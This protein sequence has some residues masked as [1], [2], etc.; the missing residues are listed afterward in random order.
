MR[1]RLALCVTLTLVPSAAWPQG[2]NPLGPEFRVNTFT[3]DYQT[4]P[5]IAADALG[6]FVVVWQSRQQDGSGYGI[7]GQRYSSSGVPLGLEF[8]V[9]SYTTGNQGWSSVAADAAGNFVVVWEGYQGP[10]RS[11]FGQRYAASGLPLGPEFRVNTYLG[12]DQTS[13]SVAADP[14]G[15]FVVVWTSRD[16]DGSSDGV[17]GQRFAASGAPLGPE[18]RVN[19]FTS[20]SQR[21]PAVAVGPAGTFVVAWES[22]GQ[23]GNLYLTGV[24]AQRFASSG[25]PLGPEFR[26]NT[27]TTSLQQGADVAIDGAGNFLVVWYGFGQTDPSSFGVFGQRY[28]SSGAP[29]GTE[30]RVNTY[31]TMI[32]SVPSVAADG[33]RFVVVWQSDQDGSGVGVFGQRYDGSG[34]PHGPE[35]R[36][37]TYTTLAQGGPAVAASSSGSF[38]VVW[39]DTVQD[40]SG[41]GVFGQRYDQIVPVELMRFGVE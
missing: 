20:N 40:G 4:G 16:Q 34:A 5:S 14:A 36:V 19:T 9:N 3:P 2:G 35:F 10:G 1:T 26:A 28:A 39:I 8:R 6:N 32:Q 33:G 24:F 12:P 23:D 31:T 37:N 18:F 27:Y 15:P 11:V 13:P 22:F 7:F 21:V 38:V 29:L 30:F 41:R 25:A 17:F